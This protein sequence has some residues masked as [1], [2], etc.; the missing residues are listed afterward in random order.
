MP[1]SLRS[2]LASRTAPGGIS[3][4]AMVA[5]LRMPA[6]VSVRDLITTLEP[7]VI[8]PL[9]DSGTCSGSCTIMLSADGQAHYTGHVHN[10]GA[11][12]LHY[13]VFT[14]IAAILEGENGPLLIAHSGSIGGTFSF[15]SRNDEWDEM[16]TDARL[17]R[18]WVAIK[19]AA[20]LASTRFGVAS[21]A[22]DVIEAFLGDAT[23]IFVFKL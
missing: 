11:L 8:T 10:S 13:A 2:G 15:S 23:G 3:L 21:G 9:L 7:V 1:L 12:S 14:A 4:R 6:P 19:A 17:A 16:V 5:G 20:P 22:T 18:N